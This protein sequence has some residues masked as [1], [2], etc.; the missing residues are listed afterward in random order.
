MDTSGHPSLSN[1]GPLPG[2]VALYATAAALLALLGW[3]AVN[4]PE[5]VPGHVGPGGVVD[6]WGTRTEHLV[7]GVLVIILMLLCFDV[8]MR[9]MRSPRR[10]A[11]LNLP[12]KEY[13][14]RPEHWPAAHR[15]LSNQMGWMGAAMNVFIGY[16]LFMSGQIALGD[17]PGMGIFWGLFA[18]LMVG[19][20]GYGVWS[21]TSRS[22]RPPDAPGHVS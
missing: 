12:N 5:K 2:R 16:A 21:S 6:R 3:Q 14:T 22:W 7:M 20:V 15:R 9:L 11:L 17:D 13:W 8:L 19:M 18:V 1:H 4:L 10:T